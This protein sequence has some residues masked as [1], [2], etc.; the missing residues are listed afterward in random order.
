MAYHCRLIPLWSGITDPCT[1]L[2]TLLTSKFR[3]WFMKT[4]LNDISHPCTSWHVISWRGLNINDYDQC[5]SQILEVPTSRSCRA[6][7]TT[8]PLHLTHGSDE[9]HVTSSFLFIWFICQLLV[10]RS[11]SFSGVRLIPATNG[12]CGWNSNDEACFRR[13]VCGAERK[14]SASHFQMRRRRR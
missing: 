8:A 6:F 2:K 4:D 5:W 12:G 11:C 7:V 1:L 3:V 10:N 13:G 9:R 14:G